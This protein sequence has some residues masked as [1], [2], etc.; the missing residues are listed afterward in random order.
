MTCKDCK[1][2][3]ETGEVSDILFGECHRYPP[4]IKYDYDGQVLYKNP[5]ATEFEWCGEFKSKLPPLDKIINTSPVSKL[6]LGNRIWHR[7]PANITT[8]GQLRAFLPQMIKLRG[9]GGT[10][11][12]KVRREIAEY[13]AMVHSQAS[14]TAP[15][16]D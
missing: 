14:K 4:S 7:L 16:A 1:F 10:A 6:D 9:I 15:A 8:I 3:E 2:W 13:E 11:M 12:R 5:Y